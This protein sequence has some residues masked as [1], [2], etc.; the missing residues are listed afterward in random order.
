MTKAF[1]N[2]EEE[3]EKKIQK[4]KQPEWIKPMLATLTDRR[5]SEEGW[6]FERKLD[7]E[8]CIAFKNGNKV[9]LLSRNK[10]E[11]NVQ[12][13]EILKAVKKQKLNNFIVDGEI[14]AFKGNVTSFS[15]L[16]KRMHV[17]DLE[18]AKKSKI[19]VY[20]YIFDLVYFNEFDIT[21]V[22]LRYRKN[23]LRGGLSFKD[24]IRFVAHRN[25]EGESFFEEACKKGWEG[26]IAK[27]ATSSYI[28]KRSKKWLKFKCINRQEFII[29]GYTEP[30]GER[31]GFGALL[32]GY[33]EGDNLIYAGKVGT[34]F[35]DETLRKLSKKISSLERKTS[36]FTDFDLPG[37]EVHWVKV[38]LVAQIGFE[39][40][41]DEGKLRQP[42]FQGLR[43]DKNPKDVVREK[44]KN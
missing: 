30:H 9:K 10:K 4:K 41:T 20:Y 6:I 22:P 44:A 1:E 26:I 17:K 8:R 24:P 38:E 12:Y 21:Q 43:D 3:V 2:L 23:L 25:E 13:P 7:G 37:K 33:Y 16:Q 32:L 28:Q 14:V 36:P 27:E 11:L 15:R 18:E 40:W 5:F 29:G 35:D 42:R 39:Q 19:A 31:I 34:G